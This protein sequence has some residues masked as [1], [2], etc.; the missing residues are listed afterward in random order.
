MFHMLL[1]ESLMRVPS[2]GIGGLGETFSPR[3]SLTRCA[4]KPRARLDIC[5]WDLVNWSRPSGEKW[6]CKRSW[7][8]IKISD[9]LGV[10]PTL[11][12]NNLIESLQHAVGELVTSWWRAARWLGMVLTQEFKTPALDCIDTNCWYLSAREKLAVCKIVVTYW[13]RQAAGD[14]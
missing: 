2:V 11:E 13:D 4:S 10:D 3:S 8:L 7:T 12:H 1:N 5:L 9:C 14:W 6:K